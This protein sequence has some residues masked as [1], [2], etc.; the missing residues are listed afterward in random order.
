MA[1]T[2]PDTLL[3]DPTGDLHWSDFAGAI[4]DIFDENATKHP[5]RL[6]VIETASQTTPQRQF[7]Y[8]Q[9]NHGSNQLA[10]HLIA[11][12]IQRG[13]VVQIYAYRGVDLVVAIMGTLKAGA[14]FSV[15]DPAYPVDRQIVYLDVARPRALIVID[16]ASREEGGLSQKV[17]DSIEENLDLRTTVPGLELLNDGSLRGGHLPASNAIDVLYPQIS[18]REK[19]P[20]VLVGPDTQPTLSFTS[21]SEGVPK[22]CRCFRSLYSLVNPCSASERQCRYA[23]HTVPIMLIPIH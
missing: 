14:A 13:E 23:C 5:D 17:T 9:I 18:M 11:A 20:G 15:V 12:G 3:P 7:T 16:K 8:Q 22:G 10:H 19:H 4:Q 2:L 6:C 1:H 21:G